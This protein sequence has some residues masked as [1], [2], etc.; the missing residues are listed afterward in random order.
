MRFFYVQFG[1]TT[2]V[3][4]FRFDTQHAVALASFGFSKLSFQI[5]NFFI[6][7]IHL[8]SRSV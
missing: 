4:H 1:T 6:A 5:R 2:Q 8:F 7:R 3:F